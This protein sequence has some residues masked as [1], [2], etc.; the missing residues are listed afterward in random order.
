MLRRW[1][2][3]TEVD[4]ALLE[5]NNMKITAI[6]A[7]TEKRLIGRD[8]ELA[9]HIPEDLVH[10]KNLTL[11]QVVI[12]G[13]NTFFSIPEKFRPLPGRRNIVL[14]REKIDNID[15]FSGISEMLRALENEQR[16]IF[17]IGGA[18]LYNQ[19]FEKNLID[20]VELTLLKNDFS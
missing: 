8:N 4:L 3:R 12:M 16:K 10:F 15:C 18:S 14:T 6:L 13:R 19:F 1:E 2:M 11:G 9:W 5:K 20:S 17:V 7:M